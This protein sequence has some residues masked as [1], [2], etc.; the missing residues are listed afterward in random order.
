MA[1]WGVVLSAALIAWTP[2]GAH[3]EVAAG[4]CANGVQDGSESDV[5]C[6]GDCPPC[7]HG[8]SCESARDCAS[9]R[10]A[11]AVCEE[12]RY[13]DGDPVPAGYRVAYSDTDS[14]ALARTIGLVSLGV[15][16]GVA[17]VAALSL[18]GEYSSLYIPVIGPWLVVA[19]DS[20]PKR[21]LIALDGALQTVGISLLVGGM[22]TGGYQLLRDEDPSAAADVEVAAGFDRAGGRVQLQGRF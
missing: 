22:L 19:D 2:A 16:Y 13:I 7:A 14:S 21:G 9:G 18:P 4:S 15:G 1:R 5:D 20:K 17:Y 10:C 6:G 11:G 3:A 8:R 12:R